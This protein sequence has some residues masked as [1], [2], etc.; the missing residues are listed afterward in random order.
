MKRIHVAVGLVSRTSHL[1]RNATL[2]PR[3]SSPAPLPRA[4]PRAGFLRRE[5]L[6]GPCGSRLCEPG[7][8]HSASTSSGPALLRAAPER[9]S[10]PWPSDIPRFVQTHPS[11]LR[12][13]SLGSFRGPAAAVL[14]VQVAVCSPISVLRAAYPEGRPLGPINSTFKVSTHFRPVPPVALSIGT[15]QGS[16]SCTSSALPFRLETGFSGRCPDGRE[17]PTRAFP[18]VWGRDRPPG[19]NREQRRAD[20]Q[21]ED[22]PASAPQSTG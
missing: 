22:R 12:V 10:F 11:V 1:M 9:P 14:A 15:V 8:S 21:A 5:L 7:S 17:A 18:Q 16:G 19:R 4:A 13:R 20:R 3:G 6:R 2:S